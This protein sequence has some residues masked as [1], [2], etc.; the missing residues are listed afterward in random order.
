METT[1]KLIKSLLEGKLKGKIHSF[2]VGDPVL[3]PDS[4]LP[5]ISIAPNNTIADIADNQRDVRTHAIDISLI[6]D[7]R[8]F[9]NKTPNEMVGTTYL[10]ETMSKENTDGTLDTGSIMGILRGNLNLATNRFISNEVTI[11]YTTRRRSEDLITLEAI[12]TIHVQQIGNR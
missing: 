1:I 6:I 4:A 3:I 12:A 8:Q 9:F 5:C 11:D 10:M 7:A 2:Y